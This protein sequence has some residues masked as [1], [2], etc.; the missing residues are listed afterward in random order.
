MRKNFTLIELLVVIAIIAILASMLLPALNQARERG[1]AANCISNLRQLGLGVGQYVSD[2]ADF[3]PLTYAEGWTMPRRLYTET[4]YVP[5]TGFDCPSMQQSSYRQNK[6]GWFAHYAVNVGVNG[7]NDTGRRMTMIKN[8]SGKLHFLDAWQNNG[9][10]GAVE[11]NGYFR[12]AF[13]T[14]AKGNA[15][16]GRPASRHSSRANL[17]YLDGHAA[18]GNATKNTLNP[19]DV[20]PF[21]YST[22]PTE[23]TRVLYWNVN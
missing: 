21:I 8:A 22:E 23:S 13:D 4:K 14:S 9:S 16:Y 5:T 17:L 6:D 18:V 1:K 7:D 15:N 12:A 20:V 19:F 11:E 10:T 2:N 3:L